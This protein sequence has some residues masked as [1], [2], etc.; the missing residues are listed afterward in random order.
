MTG[1]YPTAGRPGMTLSTCFLL[2]TGFIYPFAGGPSTSDLIM[3]MADGFN[4]GV[5]MMVDVTIEGNLPLTIQIRKL[6]FKS[7]PE[8]L[9]FTGFIA[10]GSRFARVR[11]TF[12]RRGPGGEFKLVG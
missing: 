1:I 4:E 6:S 10:N 9:P 5:P 11:G 7:G 2:E 12:N 3:M 8:T